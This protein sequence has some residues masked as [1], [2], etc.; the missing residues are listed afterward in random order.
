MMPRFRTLPFQAGE[1]L[2]SGGV[3]VLERERCGDLGLGRVHERR[4]LDEVHTVAAVIVGRVALEPSER[5]QPGLT[6]AIGLDVG[7]SAD[8]IAVMRASRPRSVVSVVAMGAPVPACVN[9]GI[10]QFSRGRFYNRQ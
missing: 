2:T 9:A 10:L 5:V 3:I 1:E 6:D 4:Q 8:R 7:R